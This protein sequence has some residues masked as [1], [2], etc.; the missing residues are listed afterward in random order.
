MGEK[1]SEKKQSPRISWTLFFS[2]LEKNRVQEIL[3][4][5]FFPDHFSPMSGTPKMTHH[6]EILIQSCLGLVI[7]LPSHRLGCE[8][9]YACGGKPLSGLT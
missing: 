2:Q 4:L 8:Y 1:W 3:G 5:C 6:S 9:I 7:K